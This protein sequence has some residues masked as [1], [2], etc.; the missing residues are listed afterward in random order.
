MRKAEFQN[1]HARGAARLRSLIAVA[2]TPAVKARLIERAEESERL[3]YG[4]ADDEVE[5]EL[6]RPTSW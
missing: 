3:A 6:E 4:F 1:Y 5:V 2:T